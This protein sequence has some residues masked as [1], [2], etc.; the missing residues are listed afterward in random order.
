M[1]RDILAI[2]ASEAGVERLFNKGRDICHY[3]RNKLSGQTIEDTM[4]VKVWEK[5]H[6]TIL[7]P[8]K[9]AQSII[10]ESDAGI[11]EDGTLSIL[12]DLGLTDSQSSEDIMMLEL[13]DDE[14]AA[15]YT[16]PF[17]LDKDECSD[18]VDELEDPNGTYGYYA[19]VVES[20]DNNGDQDVVQTVLEV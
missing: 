11:T 1:A 20:T 9:P 5:Q 2:P 4:I 3:R 18:F 10:G 8:P 19:K 7:Q 17:V 15:I 13:E 12:D 16:E 14:E 6:V